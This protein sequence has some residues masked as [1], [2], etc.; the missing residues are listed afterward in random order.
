MKKD[1]AAKWIIRN[2]KKYFPMV[3]VISLIGAISAGLSVAL[4]MLSKGI[5]DVASG[6]DASG[7]ILTRSLI[8][9]GAVLLGVGCSCLDSH[10]RVHTRTRLEMHIKSNLLGRYFRKE[11]SSIYRMHSGDVTQRLCADVEVVANGV[12]GTVPDVVAVLLRVAFGLGALLYL[13]P[14]FALLYTIAGIVLII[15][16]RLYGKKFKKLHKMERETDGQVRTFIQECSGNMALIKSFPNDRPFLNKLG[17]KMEENYRIRIKQNHASNFVNAGMTLLFTG[18]YY[19]V[20]AWGALQILLGNM[21]YGV[22]IALLELVA[23]MRGPLTGLSGLLP[24]IFSVLASAERLM[25]IEALPEEP[26]VTHL[27]VKETYDAMTAIHGREVT[28]SY[29]NEPVL[30]GGELYIEKG[31]IAAIIGTSGIGKTT[32]LRILLG[33]FKPTGGECVLETVNGDIHVGPETRRLFAYVPQGSM[34]LSGSLRENLM[35]GLDYA[36]DEDIDRAIDCA[37]LRDVVSHLPNGIDTELGEGGSG[38]SQGQLQRLAVARALLSGAP[39]LLLD[40]ATAGLDE[41]TERAMLGNIKNTQGKTVILV[42]HRLHILDLCDRT[43]SVENGRLCC[44]EV[45]EADLLPKK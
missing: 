9:L 41:K 43:I 26:D 40:E 44:R 36:S 45:T 24:R 3:A 20:M 25:D 30:R 21:T 17:N 11:Y 34:V 1:K 5:M 31:Q 29:G 16:S 27:P 10:L 14:F 37:M 15:G 6:D 32:M 19:L 7:N 8:L 33:Y 35:L 38:L 2:S 28:F 23:Q 42:T 12:S 18:G 39:I 22:F 13:D 4:A